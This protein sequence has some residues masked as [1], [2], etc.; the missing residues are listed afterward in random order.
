MDFSL[1]FDSELVSDVQRDIA[2]VGSHIFL[3]PSPQLVQDLPNSKSAIRMGNGSVHR[4]GV[5]AEATLCL[6]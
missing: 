1:V 6:H 4:K 5:D 2:G 3:T